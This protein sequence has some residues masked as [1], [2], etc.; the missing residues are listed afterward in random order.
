MHGP[1]GDQD[2]RDGLILP[3]LETAL[4][5]AEDAIIE[6]KHDIDWC[7]A[8]MMIVMDEHRRTILTLP[9]LPGCA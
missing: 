7:R 6:R 9:F 3:N 4:A 1:D 8:T 2:D 5:H